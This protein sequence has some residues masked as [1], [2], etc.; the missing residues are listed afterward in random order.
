MPGKPAK[1]LPI[2]AVAGWSSVAIAAALKPVAVE[3]FFVTPDEPST[4]RWTVDPAGSTEPMNAAVRDYWGAPAASVPANVTSEGVLEATVRLPAGYYDV[5]LPGSE[6]RFGVMSLRSYRGDK[7][8]FFSIDAAMSWLVGRDELREGLIQVLRQ[9]GIVMSRERLNWAQISPSEG[10]WDW[11]SPAHYETIRQAYRKHGVEVLEMFHGTARW[12]GR[13]GKYPDDLVG[14]MRAWGQ[15]GRRWRPTWGAM[16]VW[17]EPDIS[18]GDYLPADQYVPLVKAIAYGFARQGVEVPIVGGVFAHHHPPFLEN[19]AGNGLLDCVDVIS[20]HTYGRAPGMEELIGKYRSWLDSNRRGTIPLWLTECGRPWKRGPD[21]PPLEQDAESALDV[22]MKAVESRACGIA[23]Y[24]AFV[25]PFYE[26]RDNN[27]GLMGRHGTPLRS[28]AAYAWLTSLLANTR[29][30][31]DLKRDD[32]TIQ[33][34]RVFGDDRRAVA[35]LY[36][37]RP[38]REAKLKLDLP[39]LRAEGIDGRNL[40]PSDDGTVPVP[41]G[42]VYVWLDRGTLGDRLETETRAMELWTAA[43]RKAPRPEAPLPIVLRYQ[44]DAERVEPK[45]DGYHLKGETDEPIPMVVRVFNLSEVPR[46]VALRLVF[47]QGG[48]HVIDVEKEHKVRVP[49]EGSVDVAWE[50]NPLE[51]QPAAGRRV[52]VATASYGEQGHAT[53]Q[54]TLQIDLI[55][56]EE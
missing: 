47:R 27:F 5:E 2:F 34:A 53:S 40:E 46:D 18:F 38:D 3:R 41:D 55:G 37:G 17:N 51:E 29:Y 35:V 16:E 8:P 39:V 43:R 42:L 7:D 50:I 24:F 56:P 13:V 44:F 54:A 33:R 14:T 10:T 22:A 9:S 26:E 48:K 11:D 31:G 32:E 36:T 30:L 28:M 20:F 19:A 4:L 45:S 23:R 25:Y 52:A 12:A 21:R 1:L 15:I 6:Q 49:A